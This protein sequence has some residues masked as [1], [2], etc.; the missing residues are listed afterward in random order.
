M[1]YDMCNKRV[2]VRDHFGDVEEL[3]G[4][5]ESSMRLPYLLGSPSHPEMDALIHTIEPEDTDILTV[6]C[7]EV[8]GRHADIQ[9]SP[10]FTGLQ[11]LAGWRQLDQSRK[12]FERG[13]N[14]AVAWL[15]SRRFV[16]PVIRPL[17]AR[18]DPYPWEKI[19]GNVKSETWKGLHVYWRR[20]MPLV[21]TAGWASRWSNSSW[22]MVWIAHLYWNAIHC[23]SFAG[24]WNAFVRSC[25]LL[26]GYLSLSRH[27][28]WQRWA[29]VGSFRHA[30]VLC[31]LYAIL[32]ALW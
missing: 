21:W 18:S 2:S 7:M 6:S 11:V 1:Y 3:R 22:I 31:V 23:V 4:T 30:I 24:A 15:S 25:A 13:F 20:C 10:A 19:I 17:A 26:G 12:D 28:K 5:L 27:S 29:P 16:Q 14:D 8:D 32:E 9:A